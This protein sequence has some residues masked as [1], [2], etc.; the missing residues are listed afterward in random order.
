[1]FCGTTT[2]VTKEMGMALGMRCGLVGVDLGSWVESVPAVIDVR[3]WV[4]KNSLAKVFWK[5]GVLLLRI[6]NASHC[7]ARGLQ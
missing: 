6:L 3:F 5:Y 2:V 1:M 7:Q 4:R